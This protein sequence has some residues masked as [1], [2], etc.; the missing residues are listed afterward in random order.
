MWYWVVLVLLVGIGIAAVLA[1]LVMSDELATLRRG[2]IMRG[3][4]KYNETTGEW[5]WIEP[6][7]ET[8]DVS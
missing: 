4:A 3:Y 8:E 7:E 5:R 6:P 2:A 1:C